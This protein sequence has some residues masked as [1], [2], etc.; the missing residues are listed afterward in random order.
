M[1]SILKFIQLDNNQRNEA[2]ENSKEKPD[3]RSFERWFNLYHITSHHITSHHITSHHNGLDLSPQLEAKIRGE[4]PLTGVERDRQNDDKI[5]SFDLNQ[6]YAKGKN[7]QHFYHKPKHGYLDRVLFMDF[8]AWRRRSRS[9]MESA[10]GRTDNEYE[11][12]DPDRTIDA[13]EAI[14]GVPQAHLPSSPHLQIAM[15]KIITIGAHRFTFKESEDSHFRFKYS[16]RTTFGR[17]DGLQ[18]HLSGDGSQQD[19]MFQGQRD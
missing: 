2:S 19:C 10:I 3:G 1:S 7:A 4:K 5:S 13:D 16:C 17:K 9:W 15:T 11:I 12:I 6:N 14:E 18:R 8:K